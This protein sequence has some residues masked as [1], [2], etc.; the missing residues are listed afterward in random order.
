MSEERMTVL[1]NGLRV[2]SETMPR[3]ETAAFGVWVDVGARHETPA[4]NGVAHM[5]EHMAFKGTKRRNA[6]RIAEEIEDAGGS[7]NAYTS[8]EH[9]AYHARVLDDGLPLAADMIADIL[10]GSLLDPAELEK[11][12][13]VILQEIGEAED[14]PSDLVF[15]LLQEAAFP[16]QPLGRPILG[17]ETSVGAMPRQA[18][19]DFV[20]AHYVPDRL[21]VAAAGSVEHDAVVDLA[22]KHLG[23]LRGKDAAPFVPGRFAPGAIVQARDLEQVHVCLAIEAFA[24]TDADFWALQ[25]FSTALGGGMA[26]RLFQEAR[27]ERGLCY[28]VFSFA[29]LH[30]D[31]GMLGLYAATGEDEAP[32]LVRVMGEQTRMLGT[33]ITPAEI[34]RAKA[35]LKASQ[36]MALESCAAVAE[37]LARQH[38]MY[39]EYLGTA[40]IKAKIDAVTEADLRR[41]AERLLG[42][43]P[44]IATAMIGPAKGL[45]APERVT[46]A[47]N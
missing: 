17:T 47:F 16:D 34:N 46:E 14:T 30:A 35:Q 13:N 12:R 45:V 31:T 7:L 43:A 6:R 20:D 37:D 29:G 28:S 9:T 21:V 26:S 44:K 4:T 38:L 36:L 33:T 22:A 3:L 10:T 42:A 32:D 5:L 40:A 25:L 19:F 8:R 18:L 11:E 24:F 41:V 23:D 39:G 27:E 2:V 15:D 1:P